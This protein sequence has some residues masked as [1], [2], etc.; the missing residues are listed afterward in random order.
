[1]ELFNIFLFLHGFFFSF[2]SKTEKEK[3]EKRKKTKETKKK[4]IHGSF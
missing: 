2:F 4:N 3:K 1:M